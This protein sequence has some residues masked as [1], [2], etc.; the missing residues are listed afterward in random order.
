[1]CGAHWS[2]SRES[3]VLA[4]AG[5]CTGVL[6][7]ACALSFTQYASTNTPPSYP[8]RLRLNSCSGTLDCG[9]LDT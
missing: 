8:K 9:H 1:M 5:W 7:P 4:L 6:A 2:A 3:P